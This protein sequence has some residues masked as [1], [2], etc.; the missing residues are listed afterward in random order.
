MHPLVR[1]G[2]EWT[3]RL[4]VIFA[5]FITFCY[6]VAR[7]DTVVI[8]LG[9]ALLASAM[10]L[11]LV[12]WMQRR[13]VPR[14]AA[15]VVVIIA[16]IGV[17]AGIMTFVVEQFIEG[18]PQLG[19][20]FTTSINDVQR[21]LADGPFHISQDQIS[22]ASENLVKV[23]QDNQAAVTSG[24]LTTATVI[25]E[26]LTGAALT[27][28]ILIFFL[29]GGDQIW[30]FV[31]RLAPTG[32]RRRIRLAGSQGFGS[33][34]GYVRATVAVAAADAIGIGAGLAILGVPLALPLASLVF[35]GAFIPIVGAFLTGFVAV[36]IALVTKGWL[37]ALITLGIVVAVMQL[38]GHVLQP[39]L[40]GRAVRL[41]PLA[42][43]L[44]IT[45]GILLAGIV[46]GL[47]AVPI[48]AVLNT[49][50]RSLLAD[51]PDEVYEELEEHDPGEPLFPAEADS[52][53]PHNRELDPG[54]LSTP[55]L[56]KETGSERKP[57]DE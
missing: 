16:S 7:L 52:P 20:Q 22:Q 30:E 26:I 40:L 19:D 31:T 54:S 42:V 15:V 36:F 24:A 46:G 53:H 10:L 5:G 41:H 34:V 33:L 3:W 47:L 57:T 1:I 27:L 56:S 9:L 50:V 2:A 6:V 55:D 35:I 21:W 29:Y 28:F 11:P 32:A 49:A 25:G 12:D 51:D 43:V 44:A 37:T 48:V 38:E 39:L 4:L 45:V 8:P 17:V 23:I 18:L 14:A 13:G